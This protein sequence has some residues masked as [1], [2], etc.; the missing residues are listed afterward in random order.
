MKHSDRIV[1]I[2]QLLLG[3][4]AQAQSEGCVVGNSLNGLATAL[5]AIIV[6]ANLRSRPHVG[7]T[8]FR[9]LMGVAANP[10]PAE[11]RNWIKR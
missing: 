9:V 3:A 8:R 6:L 10:G 7:V 5:I 1:G 2:R 11:A 4:N